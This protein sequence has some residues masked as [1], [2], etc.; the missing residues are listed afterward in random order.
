MIT[1]YFSVLKCFGL[2]DTELPNTSLQS[3]MQFKKKSESYIQ[4]KFLIKY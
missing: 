2:S 1:V 3:H 4:M